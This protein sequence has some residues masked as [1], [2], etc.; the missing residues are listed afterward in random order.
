MRAAAPTAT[1][2]PG[3]FVVAGGAAA[4]A[5]AIKR[6][7]PRLAFLLLLARCAAAEGEELE[8]GSCLLQGPLDAVPARRLALLNEARTAATTD[9]DRDY[10]RD[11]DQDEEEAADGAGGGGAGGESVDPAGDNHLYAEE[12]KNESTAMAL[13]LWLNVGFVTG[14]AY[15]VH[16]KYAEVW[17]ATFVILSSTI[18]IFCAVLLFSAIKSVPALILGTKKEK[19]GGGPDAM[20][21]ATSFIRLLVLAAVWQALLWSVRHSRRSFAMVGAMGAEV[22]G[23]AAIDAFGQVQQLGFFS[24]S[25]IHSFLAVPIACVGL[26]ALCTVSDAARE[27]SLPESNY[28][29]SKTELF[30]E[31]CRESEDEYIGLT[32]GLLVS[33]VIRFAIIGKLPPLTGDPMVKKPEDVFALTGACFGTGILIILFSSLRFRPNFQGLPPKLD[34]LCTILMNVL[35]MTL[36]W[37]LLS[38]AEWGYWCSTS[39]RGFGLGG[40][41]TARVVVALFMFVFTLVGIYTKLWVSKLFPINWSGLK[42]ANMVQFFGLLLGLSWKAVFKEALTSVSMR[43]DEGTIRT[44]VDGGL[45]VALCAF[46]IPP[47]TMYIIPRVLDIHEEAESARHPH[48]QGLGAFVQGGVHHPAGPS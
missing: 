17:Q 48:G 35:T 45:T 40:K 8:R 7:P 10:V 31:L 5:G 28:R 44:M 3:L 41:M 20:S 1:V 46:V 39:D 6:G 30:E 4:A 47:W 29:S 15:L 19:Y 37:C 16:S 13:M 36:G 43:W 33:L 25:P 42:G 11:D 9:P 21:L 12:M 24:A 18:S 32:L 27:R 26:W 2:S 14:I 34:R 22:I 23:F 38:A